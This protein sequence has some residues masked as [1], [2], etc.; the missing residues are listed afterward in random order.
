MNGFFVII[1]LGVIVLGIWVYAH[2]LG[3]MIALAKKTE[4]EEKLERRNEKL[5]RQRAEL[6][7]ENEQLKYQLSH[8]C[9]N[10]KIIGKGARE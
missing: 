9:I 6:E 1:C 3:E 2:W 10:V 4:R 5:R 7:L 8:P